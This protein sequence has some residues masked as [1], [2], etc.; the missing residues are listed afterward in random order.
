[1]KKTPFNLFRHLALHASAHVYYNAECRIS[2]NAG[3]GA[4][5]QWTVST[6]SYRA[7]HGIPRK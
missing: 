4:C 5:G 7:R 3:K 6:A 1:M 2:E